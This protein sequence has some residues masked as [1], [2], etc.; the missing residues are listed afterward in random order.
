M[1]LP[2]FK[3]HP[4]PVATGSVKQSDK[5]CECCRQA[6]GYIY[7][8]PVYCRAEVKA[9]C[10]WCIADG[11]THEKFDA[12]F[13]DLASVGGCKR[14]WDDVPREVAEEVA[15]R[16]PGFVTWQEAEWWSHC[17]DAAEFLGPA[18]KDEVE[19]LGPELVE[20]LRV[21]ALSWGWSEEYW[22]ETFDCFHKDGSPVAYIF[23][24]RHCG[25]YG[26]F[27]DFD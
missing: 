15:Y 25:M 12:D 20:Y 7:E 18:G 21:Q 23:R 16:T 22:E 5:V 11:S 4:D 2:E 17:G 8:G 24:C 19:A 13:T 10:P 9:V 3:Y 1:N 6:R 14:G 26:G 27:F